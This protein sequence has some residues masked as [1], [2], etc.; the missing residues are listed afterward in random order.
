MAASGD[1]WCAGPEGVQ[2]IDSRRPAGPSRKKLREAWAAAIDAPQRVF[3]C[4]ASE[5]SAEERW[6]RLWCAANTDIE[7]HA[8]RGRRNT[9]DARAKFT[10]GPG[11]GSR[12]FQ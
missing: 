7:G 10:A 11:R 6:K 4:S 3:Q 5:E 12:V 9:H 1:R 2:R 8:V